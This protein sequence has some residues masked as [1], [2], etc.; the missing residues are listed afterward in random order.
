MYKKVENSKEATNKV[1]GDLKE[2]S[3]LQVKSCKVKTIGV[4][5][6]W[7]SSGY[8][9]TDKLPLAFWRL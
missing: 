9:G 4:C 6:V 1:F 3:E 5:Y 8:Q 2:K 7:Y